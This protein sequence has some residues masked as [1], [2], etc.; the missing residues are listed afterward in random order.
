[1]KEIIHL[2]DLH[3]RCGLSAKSRYAEY[4]AVF[5]SIID[6]L[7]VYP[8]IVQKN[9]IIIIAGDIFHH[10]LTINSPGIKLFLDFVTGLAKLS[11]VYVIRGNHDYRQDIPN[12]P[13]LISA[14]LPCINQ[15][16]YLDSSQLICVDDELGIGIC[17][18]QTTLLAGN[19][20]G[21]RADI[22]QFPDP[23]GFGPHIKK[24]VAL[25][26]GTV[27]NTYPIEWFKGYDAIIL[28]DIHLQQVHGV[29]AMTEE[30]EHFANSIAVGQYKFKGQ[31]T[32][33]WGYPGSTIQQDFGESLVGHGFLIWNMDLETVK[34]YHTINKLGG[35]V[36]VKQGALGSWLV[37]VQGSWEPLESVIKYPWFPSTITLRVPNHISAKDVVKIFEQ[38]GICVSDVK[39]HTGH[40]PGPVVRATSS[41]SDISSF[42]TPE[43]WITYLEPFL[44]GSTLDWQQWIRHPELLSVPVADFVKGRTDALNSK[45]N[46]DLTVANHTKGNK[47]MFTI[48][49]ISWSWILCYANNCYVDFDK[50]SKCIH[51]IAANNGNGKTSFLETICIALFGE[52]FP[53]RSNKTFSGSL[54][55][56]EKPAGCKA[57]TQ[58]VVTV[59]SVTY[60]ICR[61]FTNVKDGKVKSESRNTTVMEVGSGNEIHSGKTALGNWVNENIGNINTFL[62]SCMVT[63]NSDMD[64]FN[65][66]GS[67]QIALLDNALSISAA[68]DFAS[69]LSQAV[70]NHKRITED[71]NTIIDTL[72]TQIGSDDFDLNK[73]VYDIDQ[74]ERQRDKILA[75][76]KANVTNIIQTYSKDDISKAIK[77]LESKIHLE[78]DLDQDQGV[79]EV[80][81]YGNL[82]VLALPFLLENMEKIQK[83]IDCCSAPTRTMEW[84]MQHLASC[85]SNNIGSGCLEH[86]QELLASLLKSEPPNDMDVLNDLNDLNDMNDLEPTVPLAIVLEQLKTCSFS[87]PLS[88][89]KG[90]TL[91]EVN[92][93]IED[94]LGTEVMAPYNPDCWACSSRI[95]SDQYE[96]VRQKNIKWHILQDLKKAW[97]R[98]RRKNRLAWAENVNQT[99]EHILNIEITKD[100]EVHG[101]YD[102]LTRTKKIYN[103]IIYTE[104]TNRKKY[105]DLV[106]AKDLWTPTSNISAINA[107]IKEYTIKLSRAQ[108]EMDDRNVAQHKLDQVKVYASCVQNRLTVIRDIV[109]AFAGFKQ[110]VYSEKVI[111]IITEKANSIMDIMCGDARPIYIVG[112][113]MPLNWFIKDGISCPPIEKASGFQRFIAG[114][115]IR[116]SLGQVG[117][118]AI[119]PTQLFLDEGFV[120]CD[121]E[122]LEKV[123]GFLNRLKGHYKHIMLVTHLEQIKCCAE[124][125]IT[126]ERRPLETLSRLQYDG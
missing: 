7:A 59:N 122:N 114:L 40:C 107:Q 57:T 117:A 89:D 35:Y 87:H 5:K 64:F 82:D 8:A 4:A 80:V 70:S 97:I 31:G 14:F 18:I 76:Q 19:T 58:I 125:V 92:S 93:T 78:V 100:L 121:L 32:V 13:D 103:K 47:H 109:D 118:A 37:M 62:L 63:Q 22:P 115:A 24:K 27:C 16:T 6:D 88:L 68:T 29:V 105:M 50:M 94:L 91:D 86:E 3:I 126:I 101:L 28:G 45:F 15:V 123:Q 84:L 9:A 1:M 30:K 69:I 2:A 77:I 79:N 56:Q 113:A 44:E 90:I 72:I 23:A 124:E 96:I 55:C 110:W 85:S 104:V 34:A 67:D 111:P 10:K 52:G 65:L 83:Q 106:T 36:T 74:L 53:S 20:S 43:S 71:V 75:A 49:K 42:N 112:E 116:L 33:P 41:E 102:A 39:I 108:K 25:F 12:E 73:M 61:E 66:K 60:K 81:D 95:G 120:A 11:Q 54:I 46:K 98:T 38:G 17:A 26:H 21:T 48:N 119:K 99:K 51:V